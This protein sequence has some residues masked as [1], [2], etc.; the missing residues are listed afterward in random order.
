MW[1]TTSTFTQAGN[2]VYVCAPHTH[3]R[4]WQN[5]DITA[6]KKVVAAAATGVVCLRCANT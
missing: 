6:K 1:S 5:L 4:P 2:H 3:I